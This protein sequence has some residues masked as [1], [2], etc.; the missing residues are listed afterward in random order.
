MSYIP[1]QAVGL[2]RFHYTQKDTVCTEE[3]LVAPYI[4]QACILGLFG[5]AGSVF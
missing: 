5:N 1:R 2:I 3:T 4:A